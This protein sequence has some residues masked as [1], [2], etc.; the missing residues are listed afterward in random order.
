MIDKILI[1]SRYTFF[2]ESPTVKNSG[3]KCA[4]PEAISGLVTVQKVLPDAY[5]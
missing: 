3:V 1:P 5:K 4:R 2:S